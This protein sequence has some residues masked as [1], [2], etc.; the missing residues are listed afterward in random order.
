MSIYQHFRPEEKG[1]IDQ[2][3]NWKTSVETTYAPKLTDFLDPREQEIIKQ[4][5]GINNDVKI[6]L[7]GGFEMA[8]RKRALLYPEYL[9]PEDEDFQITLYEVEYNKKFVNLE[10][11]QVLGSL[12]SLGLKRI[13]Y[14][15]ILFENERIQFLVTRD[16]E[17]YISTQL[18]TIG[19]SS[20]TLVK[21]PLDSALQSKEIWSELSVTSTSLRLDT[22]ASA[23]HNISRQK[24]QTL[25]QQGLTKVNW[26]L[27][28]NPAFEVRESDIIS[29]RGYGRAKI[30][31]LEG[32]TKRDKWKITAG[33]QK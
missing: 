32:K 7:F 4:L 10:H 23:I 2:V 1:F 9:Q 25:I 28:E 11:P 16:I 13:K 8:E 18:N 21:L 5:I 17:H 30:I 22:V 15:D 19:K 29:I 14:G 33:K 6:Q 12:M 27:I 20:V 26:T 24:S 3:L 31:A